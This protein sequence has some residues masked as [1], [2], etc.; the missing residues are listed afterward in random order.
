MCAYAQQENEKNDFL[1]FFDS[2]H[3]PLHNTDCIADLLK[4][5]LHKKAK[6]CKNGFSERKI[7]FSCNTLRFS[8]LR[9][10]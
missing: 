7:Y 6:V 2:S 1:D 10:A 4:T 9:G 3:V 5:A 8:G